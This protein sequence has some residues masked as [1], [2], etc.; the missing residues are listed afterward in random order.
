MKKK[1][2]A[3]AMCILLLAAVVPV[4]P[5][6]AETTYYVDAS[7]GG[8]FTTIQEAV[9]EANA[10]DTIIVRDGT[11]NENVIIDNY[12]VPALP[13]D[14]NTSGAH[15]RTGLT[16]RSENGL[17]TTFVESIGG[18]NGLHCGFLV[19]TTEVTIEGFSV[20]GATGISGAAGITVYGSSSGSC[21]ITNNRCSGN[22]EGIAIIALTGNNT[23]SNN[24]VTGNTWYGIDLANTTGN[25]VTGNT[26]TDHTANG[27]YSYGI[28]L[29]NNT[30]NNIF[31]GNT[32]ELNTVGIWIGSADSNNFFDNIFSNNNYGVGFSGNTVGNF[33]Y[34]NNIADNVSGPITLRW[35]PTS[36]DF[37]NSPTEIAYRYNGADYTGYL[38]NYWDTYSGSDADGNGIGDTPYTIVTG[39]TDNYPLMAPFENYSEQGEEPPTG[40]SSLSATTNIV[41]PMV[42]IEL[43]R[44]SIDY[45]D[46]NPGE[47]SAIETV[48]ITNTGTYDVEVTLEVQGVDATAQDFY[49]QSLYVNS[50]LYDIAAVIAS[51]LVGGSQPV[52]TQLQVPATWSVPGA[53]EATYIFWAEATL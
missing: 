48:V 5:V 45:G 22:T 38:G 15:D 6:F 52:D 7:G 17:D 13:W 51:I 29:E 35:S 33:L 37:W 24:I 27:E 47:S 1:L 40:S 31:Y 4:M 8:D 14:P 44:T 42:G 28:Y 43:D 10:G 21:T 23:I 3:L 11:Y 20:S 16:I 25:I 49:E 41:I 26:C 36:G 12:N 53:Q 39:Y 46:V 18:N 19:M 32:A 9:T 34:H 2:M 30:E 50:S